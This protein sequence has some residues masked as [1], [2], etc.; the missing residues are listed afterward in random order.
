MW[1][2]RLDVRG[3]KRLSG[4]HEFS[5]GLTLIV[6]DNEAGKSTLHEAL[7][8]SLFGFSKKELRKSGRNSSLRD[9][10]RPW[11]GGE[12]GVNALV[13]DTGDG[14]VRIEWDFD[15]HDVRLL[16]A[17]SGADFSDRV[18][19]KRKQVA[20][21]EYLLGVGLEEY[22][23]ACC[24]DQGVVNAV[25]ST[26]D[27]VSALQSSVQSNSAS[28]GV[29][30]AKE[31]LENFSRDTIGS[32]VD[33]FE[34]TKNGRLS[35]LFE[36][37][38]RLESELRECEEAR[39][40]LEEKYAE[41]IRQRANRDELKTRCALAD[42][43]EMESRLERAGRLVEKVGKYA[44]NVETPEAISEFHAELLE[45]AGQLEAYSQVD[46]AAENDVRDLLGRLEGAT[47]APGSEPA[48]EVPERDP[49]LERFRRDRERL[50]EL[51][52]SGRAGGWDSR[53]LIAA[54]AIGVVSVLLALLFPPVL[55]VGLLV[56]LAL[57]ALARRR[58]S[59]D[60][61]LSEALEG[62]GASSVEE[63][64]RKAAEE[65]AKIS[66]AESRK[67]D[68]EERVAHAEKLRE[69]RQRELAKKFGNVGVSIR[70]DEK[71]KA[72]S[73]LHDCEK[74]KQ[75]SAAA[76]RIEDVENLQELLNGESLQ[77]L[78]RRVRTEVEALG[79]ATSEPERRE[80][81]D[82]DRE[83]VRRSYREVELEVQKL[84]ARL[85]D[86][87]KRFASPAELKDSLSDVEAA[88]ERRRQGWE[89][90][91][92]ARDVMT[93]AASEAYKTFAP[94]LNQ[95]LKK[96][97]SQITDGRYQEA[98]VG[99]DLSVEVLAPETGHQTPATALSR[100]TQDQIYLVQRLEIATMLEPEIGKAPLLLDDPFARFDDRRLELG[101]EVLRDVARQRQVFLFSEDRDL[102]QR[103]RRV[104][105]DCHEILLP[106]PG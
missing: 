44:G 90:A 28:V 96:N 92:I 100:G 47:D 7:L 18:R 60:D 8:R 26:E 52:R 67:R 43:G 76:H 94:H 101:L 64:D 72:I 73:Y 56:A 9:R 3:F 53:F 10:C 75:L 34:P 99:D 79:D 102:A 42:L 27:L 51:K 82:E 31:R 89:A 74:A 97:L 39:A 103:A 5:S 87:E 71:E 59:E 88:I 98:V 66:A 14:S 105:G 16:D 30:D 24:L 45:E 41:L 78:Q 54:G 25:N 2:E 83:Q 81:T 58:S 20:L 61:A 50:L 69:D 6:G 65:D 104:C 36:E 40:G 35:A 13:R 29:E 21:G 23:G 77:Q 55:L 12:Y 33:R 68:W 48:P 85:G 11:S 84:E 17:D 80:L 37:Q 22:R 93:Q 62:Y 86:R 19:G 15:S 46:T 106:S 4:E 91:Q 57:V 95:A 38:E 70:G 63:L 49:D 1:I 32:R